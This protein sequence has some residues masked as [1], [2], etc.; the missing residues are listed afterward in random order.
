MRDTTSLDR[1]HGNNHHL[2]SPKLCSGR[3]R[4]SSIG[5]EAQ[6]PG[7]T[8]VLQRGTKCNTAKA[9]MHAR[10]QAQPALLHVQAV[11]VSGVVASRLSSH[12][13]INHCLSAS[14]VLLLSNTFGQT[15]ASDMRL[16][17]VLSR[18]VE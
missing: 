15:H 12:R 8:G 1:K 13:R 7:A 14:K 16:V 11:A 2:Q 18:P 6:R 3:P 10:L 9:L 5:Q 4:A 17:Q